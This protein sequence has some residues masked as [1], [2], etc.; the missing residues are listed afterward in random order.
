MK[1][2]LSVSRLA[3][4]GANTVLDG[5]ETYLRRFH[6]ITRRAKVRF[7][8]RDW[9]GMEIDAEE[10]LEM[11][12]QVVNQ[13]VSQVCDLLGG[14]CDEQLVWTSVKA[15]YSGLIARQDNWELAE[16]FFNSVS[17]R[18][19]PRSGV[20]PELDFVDTDFDVPPTAV[21]G[22]AFEV[23]PELTL[24]GDLQRIWYGSVASLG[25]LNTAF[26][27][28]LGSDNG[29]GFGWDDINILKL[30]VQWQYSPSL[31]LRAGVSL[32]DEL[33][34]GEKK[35]INNL[36][37]AGLMVAGGAVQKLMMK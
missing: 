12:D 28:R 23:N 21:I 7:E 25:N 30:G 1:Q 5:F 11:Q 27:G 13:T 34:S 31:T 36:K 35:V 32:A 19:F 16:T 17:R 14:R 37:K 6:E 33:F 3:N 15:V 20:D 4:M 24:V 29:L 10:R 18:V 9:K 2:S 26:E 22:F 8:Q